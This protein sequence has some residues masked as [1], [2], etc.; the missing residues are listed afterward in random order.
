MGIN[1]QQ[2]LSQDPDMLRR[3]LAMQEMQQLNPQGTA[4]GAIG[5]LL[6]RGLGNVTSGRGFFDVADPALKRVSDIQGI[7]RSVQFDPANP[8]K[9]YTEVANALSSQGYNDLAPLAA[10]EAAKFQTTK[11]NFFS[12]IDPKDYKPESIQAFVQSGGDYTK[13]EAKD[14]PTARYRTL[15]PA[16]AR[17]R[18][19]NPDNVY[20]LEEGTEK[21][22]Q[23]GQGPAVVFKAP[24]IGAENAYA[25]EVGDARAK[26]DIAQ[27]GA[28]EAATEN[29]VK[30]NETLN[31]LQTGQAFTGAF[32]DIQNNI[33]K[34]QAKFASDKK[35]GKRVTDTEYLDAL[36]GSDVFPMIGALGIGARGL[37]TPAERDFLRQVMTG[38]IKLERETLV[39]LTELRKNIAERAID[40]FNK[41]VD[42]GELKDFFKYQGTQPQK[43]EKPTPPKRPPSAAPSGVDPKIWNVMTPE[44]KAL[45]Q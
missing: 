43:F 17:A 10:A 37:D 29:L 28:A 44:E 24:L 32:A 38:T 4:A 22:T 8:S 35:A 16:E 1:A 3:Q 34:V 40:K 9:Y 25:K 12:K 14:K 15:S 30:I 7:M 2:V 13:L 20:Q 36:L 5:A 31:E 42:N 18:G 45:W 39:K 26:R 41:R 23:I 11:D 27:F 6:G 21:V 19:L 33:Q